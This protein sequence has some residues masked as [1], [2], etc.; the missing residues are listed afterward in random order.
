[1]STNNIVYTF[2]EQRMEPVATYMIEVNNLQSCKLKKHSTL[3][4]I[5]IP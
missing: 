1:M 4:Q 3:S 2:Q 5:N